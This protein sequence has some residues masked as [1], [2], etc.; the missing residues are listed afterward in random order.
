MSCSLSP[1]PHCWVCEEKFTDSG[2]EAKR[3]EHHIIPRAY[4]GSNGP[5]CSLC[6]NHHNLLHELAT[7]I[8]A[9]KQAEARSLL[10]TLPPAVKPRLASLANSIVRAH[11]LTKNDPNKRG[12][13]ILS[14]TGEQ[15]RRAILLKKQYGLKSLPA[16]FIY[17]MEQ[18][19]TNQNSSR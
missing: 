16:L 4:G 5:L 17:L 8:I 10:A 1:L 6:T 12:K 3:H 19:W 13:T 7:Y 18:A 2:G 15:Y 11:N 14:M 9:G